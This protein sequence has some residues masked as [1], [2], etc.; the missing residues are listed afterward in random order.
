MLAWQLQ[1]VH[2]VGEIGNRDVLADR[3]RCGV[4]HTRSH[5]PRT[6]CHAVTVVRS[7]ADRLDQIGPETGMRRGK[8]L[9]AILQCWSQ[10][11]HHD[12]RKVDQSASRSSLS[13]KAASGG[14]V[15]GVPE[16]FV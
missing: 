12:R 6:R 7:S 4:Q 3:G 11:V 16:T 2:E 10:G 8:T 13:R 15:R 1:L 9:S 14:S 5:L